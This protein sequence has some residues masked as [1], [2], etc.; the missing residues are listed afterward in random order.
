MSDIIKIH[1]LPGLSQYGKSLTAYSN[2]IK[3]DT[4]ILC[5]IKSTSDTSIS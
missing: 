3:V 5:K 1:N 2:Q 4:C